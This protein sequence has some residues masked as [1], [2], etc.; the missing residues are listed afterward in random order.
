MKRLHWRARLL[1]HAAVRGYVALMSC[2]KAWLLTL[3]ITLWVGFN[4]IDFP[5]CLALFIAGMTTLQ[6]CAC[7]QQ[8]KAWT[9][10]RGFPKPFL[11]L[12]RGWNGKQFWFSTAWNVDLE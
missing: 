12:V 6:L 2:S 9:G 10:Q 11:K 3:P 4:A 5:L 7:L 8:I 1:I